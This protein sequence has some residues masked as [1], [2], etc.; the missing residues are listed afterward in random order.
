MSEKLHAF[1]RH[2][3]QKGLDHGTIRRLL[4]AAGWKERDVA[5]AIAGEGLE[6]AVP[7]PAGSSA[8]RDTCLYLLSFTT[9]Y[10]TVWSVIFLLFVFLDY[11]Y[12][13]ATDTADIRG[14]VAGVRYAIAAVLVS[15][16]VFA[17]L[18]VFQERAVLKDPESQNLPVRR[19][20]TYLTLFLAAAATLGNVI[21]LLFCFLNGDLTTRF[22]L[23]AVVLLVITEIVLTYY[24]PSFRAAAQPL[25]APRSRR[26]LAGVAAMIVVAAVGLGFFLS[27]SPASVRLV[28]LDEKRID[29]LKAIHRVVQQMATTRDD[30]TGKVKLTG[31]LPKTIDEIIEYTYTKQGIPKLDLIDPQTCEPYVYVVTGGKEYELTATFDKA[32]DEKHDLF[33]N[34]RAGPHVFKFRAESPP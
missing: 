22:V 11:L 16:P 13:D 6:M 17:F 9:L 7:T 4:L 2:A 34:H 20:L 19:W 18:T 23:K 5:A 30:K 1:I 28:R 31:A 33:W 32:R 24:A 10:I 12:P 21:T 25:L 15:F 26:A 27:G 14:V 29:D 3:R 8:A